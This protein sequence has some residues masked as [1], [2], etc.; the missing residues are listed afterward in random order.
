[1]L[2]ARVQPPPPNFYQ[3]PGPAFIPPA[4]GQLP[5]GQGPPSAVAWFKAY[6]VIQALFMLMFVGFG[7]FMGLAP[8]IDPASF[9]TNPGD[10]P[11]WLI[12]GLISLAYTPAL[13]AYV[14]GIFA[15]QKKWVYTFGLVM[16]ALSFVCGGCWPL[17]IA[18]LIFWLKPEVKAW[19][20]A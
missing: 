6:C 14:V 9:P 19:Y 13:V 11:M 8:L 2:R 17:G 12:G 20:G 18:V 15:G 1:M 16:A 5:P 3:A 10:P 4:P 7:A